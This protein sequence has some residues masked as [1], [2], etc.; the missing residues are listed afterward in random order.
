MRKLSKKAKILIPVIIAAVVIAAV[1]V[2]L[3]LTGVLGGGK[4]GSLSSEKYEVV[5]I[6]FVSM[7]QTGSHTYDLDVTLE[8]KFADNDDLKI[9]F[10]KNHLARLPG[11]RKRLC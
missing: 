4:V 3:F 2:T 10:S 8:E 7:T 6:D 1:I 5:G 11:C 9:Y